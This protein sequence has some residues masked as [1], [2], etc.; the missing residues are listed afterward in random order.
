[1]Q[2]NRVNEERP[3]ALPLEPHQGALPRWIPAKGGALGTLH[4]EWLDGRGDA[5]A[6]PCVIGRSRSR[7]EL[8]IR[9]PSRPTTPNGWIAKAT[10]LLGVHGGKAPWRVSGQSPDLASFSRLP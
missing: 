2:G 10:P 3:G 9:P 5:S 8:A 4:L 1:M 6:V 7:T